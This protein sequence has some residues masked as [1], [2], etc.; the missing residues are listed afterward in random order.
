MFHSFAYASAFAS[1]RLATAARF[2]FGD[3]CAPGI[4]FRL[5]SAV[6]MIPQVTGFAMRVLSRNGG[7]RCRH[8]RLRLHGQSPFARISQD[9][10]R[11]LAAAAGAAARG[12]R[13]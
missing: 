5:M 6:E 2:T 13:G 9:R 8:A 10:S 4:T 11:D 12:D 3:S 1:S 7:D